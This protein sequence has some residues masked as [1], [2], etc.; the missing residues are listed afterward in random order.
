MENAEDPDALALR[1]KQTK[2]YIGSPDL[3][4]IYNHESL[5]I[6]HY[7]SHKIRNQASAL[8]YQWSTIEQPKY[9][10]SHL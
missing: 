4:I 10:I 3:L 8:N 6:D 7:D 2:E 9:I 1:L 5:D